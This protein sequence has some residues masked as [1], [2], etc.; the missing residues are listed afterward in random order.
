MDS[1]I[2][3]GIDVI[4]NHFFKKDTCGIP[5]VQVATGNLKL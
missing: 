2:F 5:A 1:I 4:P 3:A